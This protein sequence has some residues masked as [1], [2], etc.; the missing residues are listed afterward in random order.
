M[1]ETLSMLIN[2]GSLSLPALHA[3]KIASFDIFS[4][5]RQ[6]YFGVLRILLC[7]SYMYTKYSKVSANIPYG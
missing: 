4:G 1:L 6:L 3:T 7:K 5:K 2:L